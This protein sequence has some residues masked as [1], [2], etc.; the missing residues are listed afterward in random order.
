MRKSFGFGLACA[1]LAIATPPWA[2]TTKAP[3]TP[4]P[5]ATFAQFPA[6]SGA[7]LNA[8]GGL[9]AAKF[10]SGGEKVLGLIDLSRPGS[11]PT[12]IAR[13]GDTLVC[14]DTGGSAAYDFVL[15]IADG[16]THAADFTRDDFIL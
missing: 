4:F 12:L 3:P 16:D 13:D 15:R 6:I 7:K 5:V 14:A 1:L 8:N 9:I 10:R 11:A 2:A